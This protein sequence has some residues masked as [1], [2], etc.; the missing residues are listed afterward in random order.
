MQNM[1]EVAK[2]VELR[3]ELLWIHIT[4]PIEGAKQ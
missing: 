1:S 4:Y 2:T 3:K